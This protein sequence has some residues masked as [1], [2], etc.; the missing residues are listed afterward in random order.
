MKENELKKEYYDIFKNNMLILE[1]TSNNVGE[2]LEDFDK[3]FEYM[4]NTDN[5]LQEYLELL[6][7][8]KEMITTIL[9]QY[10]AIIHG[11]KNYFA[12]KN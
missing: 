10:S 4:R 9:L 1:T 8:E 5:D 11:M 12:E 3:T 2:L 7:E 6:K